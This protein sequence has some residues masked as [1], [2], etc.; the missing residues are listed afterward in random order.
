MGCE[1]IAWDNRDTTDGRNVLPRAWGGYS[2][3]VNRRLCF[4]YRRELRD[5]T[6]GSP[7]C[8]SPIGR[9]FIGPRQ[10]RE[11]P[12]FAHSTIHA[13]EPVYKTKTTNVREIFSKRHISLLSF[14]DT[15]KNV[16]HVY[17]L[18][19]YIYTVSMF[20]FRKLAC[21][22]VRNCKNYITK[23]SYGR[24]RNVSCKILGFFYQL[25]K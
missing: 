11:I 9:L 23:C 12:C 25:Q 6:Y 18:H 22:K 7:A 21:E 3:T 19:R 5:E 20:I 4:L 10:A 1:H 2:I 8:R 24:S 17:G 13:G 15:C 14:I 16:W